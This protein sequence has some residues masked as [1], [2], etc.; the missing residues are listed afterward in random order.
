MLRV[1]QQKISQ[2]QIAGFLVQIL[3]E[4]TDVVTA[5]Q[6][7]FVLGTGLLKAL[8]KPWLQLLLRGIPEARAVL[9]LPTRRIAR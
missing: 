3:T 9:A 2:Q 4:L 8:P 6:G 7:M 5:G 1:T